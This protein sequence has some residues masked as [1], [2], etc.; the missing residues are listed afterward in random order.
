MHFSWY[1]GGHLIFFNFEPLFYIFKLSIKC[2]IQHPKTPLT[3]LCT[4]T[5]TRLVFSINLNMYMHVHIL[6]SIE[7]V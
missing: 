3:V 5:F 6:S 2:G 4:I 1:G 7:I